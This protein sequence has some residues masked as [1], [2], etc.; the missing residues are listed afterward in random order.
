MT[1]QAISH[2][3]ILKKLGQG[4]MGE[5]YLAE[6]TLLGRRVAIKFLAQ[7]LMSEERAKKRFLREAHIVA[8]LDHPNICAIHEIGEE[9]GRRFA[10]MQYIEG[11]TLDSRMR[12]QSL[13]VDEVVGI[14]I[15]IAAALAEA[16]EHGVVH[17]D[18]KPQNMII[19]ARGQV[20]VLDFGLSK[21]VQDDT[22]SEAKT[23]SLVSESGMVIGTV[24]YMSPE[25]VQGEDLDGRSDLFSFGTL[26]YELVT[27][28]QPFSR[29]SG[30]VS[31]ISAIL[32]YEPPALTLY[33]PNVPP[34]LEEIV[35]SCLKKKR[36]ERYQ[37]AQQLLSDLK[38]LSG[39]LSQEETLADARSPLPRRDT[40]NMGTSSVGPRR[41][42]VAGVALAL[43]AIVGAGL[44][45]RS[46]RWATPL[47]SADKASA[48][49]TINSIA[50]LP[51]VNESAEPDT[52]YLSDGL[53]ESLMNDLA[54]LPNMRV[55]AQSSV[56]RYKGKQ[57]DAQTVGR[58]LNVQAVLMG[59]V[60]LHGDD[61][62]IVADLV[63]ALDNSL[64][65]TVQ[66]PQK[67]QKI[68]E[69][70]QGI[71]RAISEKLR[72]KLSGDDKPAAIR[73]STQDVQ[74]YQL[75]LKGRYAL[76]KRA[77]PADAIDYF[78]RAIDRDPV[79]AQAFSGL[80]DAYTSLGLGLYEGPPPSETMPKAAAATKRAL[81]I[82]E[83]LAEAHVSL[84]L[85]KM[86]YD[87]DWPGAD[88]QLKR[89]TELN[90][91]YAPAYQAYVLYHLVMGRFDDALA[92]N[93]KS[94]ELD[95]LSPA[96]NNNIGRVLYYSRNFDA[97]IEQARSALKT[98]KNSVP[99]HILLGLCYENKR[100]Y[101]EAI[102]TY[103][104]TLPLTK[105]A[106]WSVAA[107]GHA[108]AA[109]GKRNEALKIIEQLKEQ[110]KKTYISPF[111]IGSIYYGLGDKDQAFEWFEKAFK[112]GSSL[113]VYLKIEPEF[114]ALRTDPRYLSLM[115]RIG[116]EK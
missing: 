52:E 14:A 2:Y 85:I 39:S 114:D 27:G 12:H 55:M 6:D 78:T 31:M 32:A 9:D 67:I 18:I 38:I 115:R 26:L 88:S 54:H 36:E 4:G 84:A 56:G 62:L 23:A 110:S 71:S 99:A 19:N 15:Q 22:D 45:F 59:R 11:E 48:A 116:L 53:T 5:V 37:S 89:A 64:I 24:P 35:R 86:T 58:D 43:I 33:K 105:N 75:Y 101:K 109:S 96:F 106:P 50:V 77:N 111:H 17:R 20:K 79:Y 57:V 65:W 113:T 68:L 87:W 90:P 34:A 107:L 82:D 3:R 30:P 112:D 63:S 80:A 46:G 28:E 108:Y 74:A 76:S 70:E 29:P 21:L 92:D 1:P 44:Y 49:P 93:K 16:H 98:D 47:K 97:A 7:R 81:E 10:V 95:P 13:Q 66:Y 72:A 51:F 73:H 83:T 94:Q 69:I 25:Q 91:N 100:M 61:L 103:K 60:K 8:S 102:V 104:E 41:F 40:R 42:I